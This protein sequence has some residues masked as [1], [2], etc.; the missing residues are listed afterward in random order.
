M[1]LAAPGILGFKLRI[2][3]LWMSGIIVVQLLSC[4]WLLAIPWA[5][6]RQAPLSFTVSR[7]CSD[8]CPPS[9]WPVDLYW[10][11]ADTMLLGSCWD[12]GAACPC[13]PPRFSPSLWDVFGHAF[14]ERMWSYFWREKSRHLDVKWRNSWERWGWLQWKRFSD[15]LVVT[16]PYKH[17]IHDLHLEEKRRAS[18]FL[19][20]LGTHSDLEC[21]ESSRACFWQT[22][23]VRH[24]PGSESPKAAGRRNRAPT[25]GLQDSPDLPTDCPPCSFHSLG[26]FHRGRPWLLLRLIG[27]RNG[28]LRRGRGI[29]SCKVF[30]QSSVLL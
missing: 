6:A 21:S 5:V 29:N 24:L 26:T 3:F 28:F 9:Q 4:V 12:H 11:A 17:V 27:L 25:T 22:F 14:R 16:H 23:R 15:K 20:L 30:F 19:V 13:L 8:S 2:N 18:T 1:S 7:A 10:C